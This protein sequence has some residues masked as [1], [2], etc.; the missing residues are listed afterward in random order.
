MSVNAEELTG[1]LYSDERAKP[2]LTTEAQLKLQVYLDQLTRLTGALQSS[3]KPWQIW[4][5]GLRQFYKEIIYDAFLNRGITMPAG[6][7]VHFAGSLAKAQATEFSD[8]DAFVILKN[9]GDRE[10]VKP[11]FDDINNL[12][13]RIFGI[14]NQLYPDPIGIN[15]GRLIGTVDDLI[16][17]IANGMAPE[18]I[19]RAIMSSKPIDMNYSLGE[20]LRQRIH[21]HPELSTYCSPTTLYNKAIHDFGPPEQDAEHVNLKSHIMRP[22]DFILMG[23]REELGLYSE[24]GSHLSAPGTI[25][26][27][28]ARTDKPS[29]EPMTALI[30]SVYNKAMSKRFELH[31]VARGENDELLA[32]D[33]SEM[34][35]Q[36]AQL[37]D[38]AI[39]RVQGLNPQAKEEG[40]FARNA[41]F[42]KVVGAIALL[43]IAP[44]VVVGLAYVGLLALPLAVAAGVGLGLG[45]A[46]YALFKVG[47]AIADWMV[48]PNSAVKKQDVDVAIEADSTH[49]NSFD[50]GNSY[51]GALSQLGGKQPAERDVLD[52]LKREVLESSPELVVPLLMVVT[53][54]DEEEE[55]IVT[56]PVP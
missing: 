16:E 44:A 41:T 35:A 5:F 20:E 18:E 19:T 23:L 2:T 42:F 4:E 7:E 8:L 1:D 30:E 40:F 50:S 47:E 48:P 17:Q 11:V 10:L 49:E 21:E 9:H 22:I 38:M 34:L 43:L 39:A 36:V 31:S 37:R 29:L 51:S 45:L 6:M 3:A 12:C 33:A 26:L 52:P 27:L 28:R 53:E 32:T 24:D 46:A 55:E 56:L 25:K 15:P 13:Q 54:L 14:T